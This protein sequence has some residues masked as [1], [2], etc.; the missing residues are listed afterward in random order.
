LL[1]GTRSSPA[2]RNGEGSAARGREIFFVLDGSGLSWQDGT[3]YEVRAGDCLVHRPRAEAHTLR[4]GDDELEVLAFG[5]R[6][7][8]GGAHLP[9]VGARWLNPA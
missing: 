4:A 5:G 8:V 2:G 3:T 9:R 7:P 1:T 6:T